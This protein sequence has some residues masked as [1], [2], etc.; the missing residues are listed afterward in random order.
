MSIEPI[1]EATVRAN[2]R[3]LLCQLRGR[4]QFSRNKQIVERVDGASLVEFAVSFSLFMTLIFVLME[5]CIAFYTYGMISDCAREA[6]RWAIVRGSTCVTSASTSCTATTTTVSSHATGMGFP[7]PGG[8]T[9]NATTTYPDGNEAP[10]SR[11]KVAISYTFPIR[12]PFVPQTSLALSTAS[13][14]YILQ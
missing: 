3:P 1:H 10:G 8:G 5:T 13:E 4:F 11:V 12:I 2:R 14:M 7:N 6:T 9:I